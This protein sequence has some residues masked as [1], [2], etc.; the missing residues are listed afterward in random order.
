M[1]RSRSP[2]AATA[3]TAAAAASPERRSAI[4]ERLAAGPPPQS[5]PA[6]P[7][8]VRSP[9]KLPL[10]SLPPLR[11]KS[12]RYYDAHGRGPVTRFLQ[13]D[14]P[15]VAYPSARVAVMMLVGFLMSAFAIWLS[16]DEFFSGANMYKVSRHDLAPFPVHVAFKD[17]GCRVKGR[18]D[19]LYNVTG[20]FKPGR[21]TGILGQ[22]GSGKTTFAQQLLGRGRKTCA[23]SLGTVF[24]NGRP[25][26]LEAFLDRV[27]FVPQDDI[28]FS[29]IT[30][31]EALD[32]SAHWRLPLSVSDEERAII[33]NDT[34]T[35]LNLGAV[36]ASTASVLS[37]GERRRL[38]IGIELVARPSVLVLDE[39]TSGLDGA[40]AH[41]LVQ[42]LASIAANNVS[43]VAVLH[44]PSHRVYA[45]LQDVV[46]MHRGTIVYQ[47]EGRRAVDY[48]REV[49]GFDMRNRTDVTDAEYLLDVL[50]GQ[51]PGAGE[52]GALAREWQKR[53]QAAWHSVVEPDM[54]AFRRREEE[55]FARLQGPRGRKPFGLVG[56]LLEWT[57]AL[58][59]CQATHFADDFG[60]VMVYGTPFPVLP[61]HGLSRQVHLWFWQLVRITYRKGVG[62]HVFVV[63]CL[64]GIVAFVRSFN[65]AWS[66]RA[67]ASF[68]LSMAISLL[69]MV[70]AVFSADQRPVERAANSGMMLAAHEL[71]SLAHS[72][73]FGWF[74]CHCFSFTH[75]L[76]LRFKHSS[77]PWPTW[78]QHYEFT[79]ILHMHFLINS[80]V[81]AVICTLCNYDLSTSFIV[82]IGTL[83]HFHVFAG[84]SPTR[85]QIARDSK[86]L[87]DSLD[88]GF[89][90]DF[91]VRTSCVRYFLEAIILHEPDKAD[92]V[93]RNFV[94]AYFG[95]DET[96][97]T[98]TLTVLFAMWLGFMAVRFVLFSWANA[99]A[100]NSS[101]DLP[102]F[103]VFVLKVLLFHVVA[104]VLMT[105]LH[106]TMQAVAEPD[107]ASSA[108]VAAAVEAAVDATDAPDD[109]RA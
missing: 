24:M 41:A 69:G 39:P 28:M 45:L 104:L 81:G 48:V 105:A 107:D 46:L 77:L 100:F 91:F 53:A 96:N 90:A 59:K 99:N 42:I 80:A 68:I 21:L 72:L 36:R 92:K 78:G 16:E 15:R 4:L 94:L 98:F 25:R 32:F 103:L 26:S 10:A 66:R 75:E 57:G 88:L 12:W 74:F 63:V 35:M 20:A 44:Q 108:P 11:R 2:A 34:L 84:Y 43:V 9:V 109:K 38:S 73:I 54:D 7:V 40:H 89:M 76:M 23:T 6:T 5:P 60:C 18:G 102:L 55:G 29:D 83:V 71:A 49:G 65:L 70:G 87:F 50:A 19:I 52:V 1:P 14:D 58:D 64:A 13:P 37:G 85:S 97:F 22:S 47:G 82:A 67:S 86:V 8:Y 101:Y 30:V 27:G 17:V 56:R 95:Y 3:A 31:E 33:V 51:E 79:H 106:E 62:V 61:K 93:G